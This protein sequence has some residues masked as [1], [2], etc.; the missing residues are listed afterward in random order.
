MAVVK[1]SPESADIHARAFEVAR[2]ALDD[3]PSHSDCP[4][5]PPDADSAHVTGYHLTEGMSRY[6]AHR[7]GLVFS[8]GNLVGNDELQVAMK[9]MFD[10]LHSIAQDVLTAL[11][12][13]WN[14]PQGWFQNTLGPT[15]NHSQW[16][17]KRYVQTPIDT[18]TDN[19]D[20]NT[21]NNTILLPVHTDPSLISV[22]IHDFPGI[23]EGAMGLEYQTSD[24]KWVEISQSGH[25]SATIFVGSVLSFITGGT[26]KAAKH[27]VVLNSH[28][29]S[30]NRGRMAATLFVRP[31]GT[32]QLLVPPS[33]RFQDVTLKKQT[34]FE[35]WNSR[36]SRNYM[37]QKK[38]SS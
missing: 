37:K 23:Q 9:K 29:S 11:E 32:A 20:K 2:A 16:H 31:Q 27:R 7:E 15:E 36:V 5:I 33:R 17:M 13:E 22:V 6:N 24:G 35:A 19:D 21:D 3:E 28:G 34:T 8:D 12:Q 26:I 10:S 38:K 18:T 25:A 14:L 1:L 30:N 4:T